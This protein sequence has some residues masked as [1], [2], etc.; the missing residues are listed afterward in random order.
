MITAREAGERLKETFQWCRIN[1]SDVRAVIEDKTVC[2]IVTAAIKKL[3]RYRIGSVIVVRAA[4]M[5]RAIALARARGWRAR[6]RSQRRIADWKQNS[7]RI[8][9]WVH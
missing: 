8:S 1:A 5:A 7:R 4:V 6:I 2:T 3:R 9:P